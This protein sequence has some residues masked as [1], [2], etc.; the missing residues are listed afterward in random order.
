ML[1]NYARKAMH[2]VKSITCAT[3]K[4]YQKADSV[5]AL[6]WRSNLSSLI[7]SILNRSQHS[8]LFNASSITK[9]SY[10]NSSTSI[11]YNALSFQRYENQ[12]SIPLPFA[13]DVDNNAILKVADEQP[14]YLSTLNNSILVLHGL[15][16]TCYFFSIK[17]KQEVATPHSQFYYDDPKEHTHQEAYNCMNRN[18]RR[19]KRANKGKRACS[20]QNR[21]KRRRRFGNHRR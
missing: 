12:R 3:A 19:G 8:Q 7:P 9:Y 5:G 6:R 15:N 1:G 2:A 21:R 20:R 4:I 16:P 10:M 14:H 17:D 11:V 18:A 13:H